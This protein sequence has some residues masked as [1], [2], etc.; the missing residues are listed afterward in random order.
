MFMSWLLAFFL[1]GIAQ[2][3]LLDVDQL[4]ARE[5]D[6]VDDGDCGCTKEPTA[7]CG[8]CT[9]FDF[10]HKEHT[11]C[12]NMTFQ[13]EEKAIRFTGT[14][15]D[16]VLFNETLSA[17]NPPPFC[18]GVC[19]LSCICLQYYNIS[20]GDEGKWG[21]CLK[22][23][24]DLIVPL[25]NLDFGCF[26]LPT[27]E[28]QEQWRASDKEGNSLLHFAGS[29]KSKDQMLNKTRQW[30]LKMLGKDTTKSPQKKKNPLD[31]LFNN[32]VIENSD[33]D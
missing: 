5:P 13:V 27:Q 14:L 2:S 23:Y 16:K 31:F 33:E 26:D 10:D 24:A 32:R 8:C 11:A 7:Q 20:Y 21:G 6:F 17:R 28:G 25:F 9:K 19:P 29:N 4:K 12:M 22:I 3:S 15:D 1:T 18:Q 30:L